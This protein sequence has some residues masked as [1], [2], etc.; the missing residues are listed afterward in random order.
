MAKQ[1]GVIVHKR[2]AI[3]PGEGWEKAKLFVRLIASLGV[4]PIVFSNLVT[5]CTWLNLDV[6]EVG[7]TIK[8][9]RLK[10]RGV[11]Q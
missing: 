2:I 10:M 9:L 4:R 1:M 11:G 3:I 7:N 6:V 8:E 5:A